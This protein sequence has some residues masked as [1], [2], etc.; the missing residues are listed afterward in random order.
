MAATDLVTLAEVK[1]HLEISDT[2]QDSYLSTLIER[3][4]GY[5]EA[6]TGRKLK[7][8]TYTDSLY[9]GSGTPE[10]RLR[11]WPITAVTGVSFLDSQTATTWT[12]Q[13]LT[14]IAIDSATER[15]IRFRDG[16]W[17]PLGFQN[18]KLT[19]PAGYTTV[20]A[21]LASETLRFLTL[22]HRIKDKQLEYVESVSFQGQTTRFVS[23]MKFLEESPIFGLNGKY[24]RRDF[25]C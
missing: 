5:V 10:L 7:S 4:T 6:S 8:R 14:Y 13:S 12:A 11:E 2:S 16:L 1:E 18:V 17:F 22:L 19:H 20:P 15:V 9:D 24:T 3:V 21:E 25:A 23:P